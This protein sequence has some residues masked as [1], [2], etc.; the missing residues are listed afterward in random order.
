MSP[1]LAVVLLYLLGVIPQ[2][3][4]HSKFHSGFLESQVRHQWIYSTL[5]GSTVVLP[6]KKIRV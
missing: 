6:L 5:D 3:P 1:D 4:L 2:G